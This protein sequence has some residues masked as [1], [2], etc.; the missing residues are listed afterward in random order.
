MMRKKSTAAMTWPI[1]FTSRLL[2]A[3]EPEKQ[4]RK[5]T[6]FEGGLFQPMAPLRGNEKEKDLLRPENT[7]L[8][9]VSTYQIECGRR[10]EPG[11][12]AR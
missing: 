9:Q 8:G 5:E 11:E 3:V 10:C 2:A 12:S 6:T 4:A 1:K 7:V